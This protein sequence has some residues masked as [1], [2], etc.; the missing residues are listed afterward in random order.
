MYIL[1]KAWTDDYL[2]CYMSPQEVR[3]SVQAYWPLRPLS[4]LYF[5]QPRSLRRI[6]NYTRTYGPVAVAR[7]IR[8]RWSERLRDARFIAIGLG[9]VSAAGSDV[10]QVKAGQAVLF[11][12]PAHPECLERIVLP[13]QLLTPAPQDLVDRLVQPGS[14]LLFGKP[15]SDEE[16]EPFL[17]LA[18]WNSYSGADMES[19]APLLERARQMLCTVDPATARRL[20][21][22]KPSTPCEVTGSPRMKDTL[23]GVVFGLGNYAKTV[24]LPNL[25]SRINIACVHEVDP[26][27]V[28]RRSQLKHVFDTSPVPRPEEKYDIYFLAGYHHTHAP[29]A[30]HALRQGAWAVIEKPLVTTREQLGE[31]LA[32]M[33]EHPHKAIACYHKRYS[34]L[35]ALAREDLG[36]AKGEPID[37]TSIVF[38]MPL[39]RQHWYRWPNSRTRLTSNG[40]HWLD[41]FLFVNDYSPYVEAH[42]RATRRGDL[43]VS[44]ELANSASLNMTLTDVGSR[45]AGMNDY[46]E[47]RAGDVTARI[48]NETY[49]R[50]EN[51]QR[52]LR[53]KTITK[54]IIHERM[55][56][57]ISR[58]ILAG[59][60]GDPIESVERTHGLVLDLEDALPK[61]KGH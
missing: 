29:L 25:D 30:V 43:H 38:E 49:Y 22:D 13:P 55:Y 11:I 5:D 17:S 47:L 8:S 58:R 12:A 46:V 7:K 33:R 31:L 28:G 24:L 45:R 40:C 21:L 61:G 1:G 52:I 2:D 23:N 53:R 32:A 15:P 20:P 44:V 3:V 51:T 27:Q 18:G 26:A 9:T 59:E 36:V 6:W 42:V 4:G 56:Q 19:P 57:A 48:Q 16:G 35:L 39:P 50:S 14:L 10:Q 41:Q 54:T 60:P 37:A 34:P